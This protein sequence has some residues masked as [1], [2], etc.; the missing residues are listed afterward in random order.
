[1]TKDKKFI[2]DKIEDTLSLMTK[3]KNDHIQICK[4]ENIESEGEPF[5][6]YRFI[7]EALPEFDFDS[8]STEQ[9]FLKQNFSMP[10]LIT[11][12]TGG[13]EHGQE[14]NTALALAAQNYSIPMGLGS[15]KMWLKDTN[16]K[17]LFDVHSVAPNVFLIGNIGAVS[18]NYGVSC[19]DIKRIVN[20]FSLNAFAL[21]L[22][23]L[24]ECVQPEGE[25][26][27]SNCLKK[28][29]QI[30]KSLPVPLMVKEVGSGI[31]AKTFQLLVDAGVSAV[32]VGG[33]GGT[34]WSAIEG[35]R[36]QAE[37]SR[38]GELFRNWGY[39][40]D[41]SLLQCV[42]RQAQNHHKIELVATGGIRNGLQVAKAIALGASMVGV[43]L[44][45]FRAA[46]N[47]PKNLSPQESIEKELSFFKKSL[48]ISLF[49]SGAKSLNDLSSRLESIRR[50]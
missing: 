41:E 4:T 1:M 50:V 43:G 6:N 19:D 36:S 3:R 23:A 31:S 16:L 8:I 47:P 37:G 40:T 22:N 10:I 12:M 32:D 42:Q 9:T 15:Q 25:R 17:K 26:N 38:I 45:L 13:V 14:I 5:S 11:G 48:S 28:I 7:P 39:S 34:S 35:M 33:K 46:V 24:Q 21:H 2:L 44:P 29:E 30:A 20:E 27:F 18:L 49:C